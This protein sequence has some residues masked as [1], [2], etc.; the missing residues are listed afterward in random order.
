MY[1]YCGGK[2]LK[3]ENGNCRAVMA[4]DEKLASITIILPDVNTFE[5]NTTVLLQNFTKNYDSFSNGYLL[6]SY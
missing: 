3:Q 1:K 2:I 4:G 5:L 6:A